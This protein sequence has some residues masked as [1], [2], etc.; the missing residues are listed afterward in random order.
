ML[1]CQVC[2]DSSNFVM[3]SLA[4]PRKMKMTMKL[5]EAE[6]ERIIMPKSSSK[7]KRTLK[8]VRKTTSHWI[9]LRSKRKELIGEIR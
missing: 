5:K 9:S 6:S 3:R 2:S 1:E 8:Q 7:R 4:K